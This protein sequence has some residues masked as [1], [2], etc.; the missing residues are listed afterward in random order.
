MVSRRSFLAGAG[1]VMAVTPMV[2]AAEEKKPTQFQLA[3]MTLP[4]SQ[5]P[6]ARAIEGIQAA[7][8]RYIAWGTMHRQ[9]G[10]RVPVMAEDAPTTHAKELAARCRDAG[11]EPV[12]MFSIIYPEA[13]KGLEVLTHRIRQASAAG[14]G[15]VLTF[16]HTKGGNRAL[17][18]ERFRKLGPIARDH[19]VT[20]VVKQHGGE[21]GTGEACAE[22]V[23]EVNDDGVMVNY[24]A[25]N[26][27][28][29]LDI[30][31]QPDLKKCVDVVRSFCMK[32]HRNWPKDQDCAPGFGEIDHYRL[33][34]NVAFAGRTMPLACENISAPLLPAPQDPAAIDALARRTREYLE[35]VIAGLQSR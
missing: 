34:E 19:G 21:T 9:D 11:L 10:E 1:A 32:D 30:D 33:L 7:G 14:I 8:F 35:T 24:D 22:I 17:W 15:Q 18:I 27:M 28:D 25:G 29:Y 31:P 2:A 5:F 3:C 23:R 6:L 26:V 20:I 13:P 12:M 16:G 4:Y